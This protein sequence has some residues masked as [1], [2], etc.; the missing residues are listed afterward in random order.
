MNKSIQ[1]FIEFGTEKYEAL[2]VQIKLL[3]TVYDGLTQSIKEAKEEIKGINMPIFMVGYKDE[4]KEDKVKEQIATEIIFGALLG[5]LFAVPVNF[6]SLPPS[7][8][9]ANF[10][11]PVPNISSQ[12]EIT[13]FSNSC[14]DKS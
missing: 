10:I 11:V 1:H 7:L 6:A 5:K 3:Q 4:L 13:I 14:H 12:I 9:S 8:P 2:G